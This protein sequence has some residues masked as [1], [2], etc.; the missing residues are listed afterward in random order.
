MLANS[1]H[2]SPGVWLKHWEANIVF[3]MSVNKEM[4]AGFQSKICVQ[5]ATIII[6]RVQ[7][8]KFPIITYDSLPQVREFKTVLDSGLHAVESGFQVLDSWILC[9]WNLDPRFRLLVGF[10]IPHS[11]AQDS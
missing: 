11:R 5:V 2:T 3:L 7:Q 10:W 9:Q 6:P 8:A 4:F 1:K